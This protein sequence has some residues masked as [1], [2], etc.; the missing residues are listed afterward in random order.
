MSYLLGIT[1]GP[2]QTFIQE[3]RKLMDLYNSS[4]I[5]SQ[6]MINC[7]KYIETN[8]S[9]CELIYPNYGDI[10]DEVKADCSNYMIFEIQ[11]LIDMEEIENKIYENFKVES[12]VLK[13]NFHLFWA[14]LEND[15][16]YKDKY[17]ELIKIMKGIKNTYKFEQYEQKEGRYKCSICGKRNGTHAKGKNDKALSSDELLCELCYFKRTYNHD[18]INN[19]IPSIY[20]IAISNWENKYKEK[21]LQYLSVII[22]NDESIDYYINFKNKKYYNPN[23]FKNIIALMDNQK[24]YKDKLDEY[25]GEINIKIKELN[26]ESLKKVSDKLIEIYKSDKLNIPIPNYEY[27]FIQ[28]DIDNLGKWMSKEEVICSKDNQKEISRELI[29]FTN[30][31]S[32]EL[33]KEDKKLRDSVNIIYSGG[34]DFLA[35]SSIDNIELIFKTIEKHYNKLLNNLNNFFKYDKKITYSI[36]ITIAQCKDPMSY[37]LEKTRLELNKVKELYENVGYQKNGV[38]INYIINNGKYITTY[39]KKDKLKEFLNLVKEY[40]SLDKNKDISFSYINKLNEDFKDFN[41]ENLTN[42][43]KIFLYKVISKDLIRII[44]RSMDKDNYAIYSK[45][46]YYFIMEIIKDNFNKSKR[47]KNHFDLDIQNVINILNMYKKF[48]EIEFRD[49]KDEL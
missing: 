9:K 14:M 47:D 26:K 30:N 33:Y 24:K 43:E 20:D 23:E 22:K 32:T 45:D 16:E 42:E 5:I 21:I 40:K 19:K 17:K 48:C 3:S 29:S 31:V 18:D 25:K 2:V 49:D 8:S 37:A 11:D 38:A 15:T 27:C 6:I 34:D 39:M 7:Y 10:K 46:L 35:I 1:I 13:E 28:F 41:Y 12:K 4:K 44:S 36:S